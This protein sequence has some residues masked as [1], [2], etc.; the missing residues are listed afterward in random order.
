MG[1][2]AQTGSGESWKGCKNMSDAIR[3]AILRN[4]SL[5]SINTSRLVLFSVVRC[6]FVMIEVQKWRV[7]VF[8][9][10]V[11]LLQ[12]L[13]RQHLRVRGKSEEGIVHRVEGPKSVMADMETRG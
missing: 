8:Y 13:E 3:F 2:P 9:S 11:A 6:W 4:T 7:S 5:V 10:S 1:I 12:G